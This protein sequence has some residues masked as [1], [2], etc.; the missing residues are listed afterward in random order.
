MITTT[1]DEGAFALGSIVTTRGALAAL[2]PDEVL[3]SLQR[4]V[5]G[6]WGD[7]CEEDHVT[8]NDAVRRG[9]RIL[10]SYVATSGTKFWIITEADRS[11]TT[12]LLPEE[13]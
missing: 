10:S 7:V 2:K 4:H 11:V 6:D 1:L 9:D 3:A 12:I 13:Y 8:N 5:S